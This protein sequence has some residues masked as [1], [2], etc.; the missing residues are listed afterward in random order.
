[1]SD[2]NTILAA[3]KRWKA[4]VV[5]PYDLKAIYAELMDRILAAFSVGDTPVN[6]KPADAKR[7]FSRVSASKAFMVTGYNTGPD[8]WI[9]LIDKNSDPVNGDGAVWNEFVQS[10][11]T[12]SFLWGNRGIQLAAGMVVAN[13][14]TP[15]ALT[16]GAEDTYFNLAYL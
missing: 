3:A 11:S 1:M 2:V 13:S 15:G 7:K 5:F 8:Q 14:S 10:N 12:F 4:E 6:A 9:M 16:L